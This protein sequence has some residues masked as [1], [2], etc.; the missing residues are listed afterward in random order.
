MLSSSTTY[1]SM[2]LCCVFLS[3]PKCNPLLDLLFDF[4]QLTNASF[5]LSV[6]SFIRS[7]NYKTNRYLHNTPTTR[8]QTSGFKVSIKSFHIPHYNQSGVPVFMHNIAFY[9]RP[10]QNPNFKCTKSKSRLNIW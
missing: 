9:S 2:A 1:V 5:H 10:I 4:E 6:Y 3:L 8:L 7:F